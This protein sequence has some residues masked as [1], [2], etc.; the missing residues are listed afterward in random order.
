MDIAKKLVPL[1]V[2]LLGLLGVIIGFLLNEV[3]QFFRAKRAE[4]RTYGK[5]IY[6]LLAIRE[7]MRLIRAI[8][9]NMAK[10]LGFIPNVEEVRKELIARNVLIPEKFFEK[11]H[12]SLETLAGIDPWLAF[13]LRYAE[14]ASISANK[15][16]FMHLKGNPRDYFYTL[17][18]DDVLNRKLQDHMTKV[19]CRLSWRHGLVTW[20]RSKRRLTKEP[21]LASLLDKME[22]A[23][24]TPPDLASLKGISEQ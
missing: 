19:V 20:I 23:K 7:G 18:F 1:L 4:H 8:N 12:E 2:P 22:Q 6:D 24:K 5:L 15:K 13:E 10:E 21:D 11:Y 3:S 14:S 17:V 16:D 9:K